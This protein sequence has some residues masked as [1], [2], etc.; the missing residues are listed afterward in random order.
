MIELYKKREFGELFSDTF[1]FIRQNGKHFFRNFLLINGA[2]IL[3]LMVLAYF[4][5]K[6]YSALITGATIPGYDTDTMVENYINNN[7][8]LVAVFGILFVLVACLVGFITYAYTPIY[9][10]LYSQSGNAGFGSKEIVKMLKDNAGK[11]IIFILACLLL[12]IP[13]FIGAGIVAFVMVIT[14]IGIFCLPLLLATI[15]LTY[16]N[17]LME[18]L[19]S[20]KGVFDCFEYGMKLTFKKFWICVGSVALFYFMIQIVQ[21]LATTIPYMA[22]IISVVTT[23][24]SG[25]SEES[26]ALMMTIMMVFYLFSFILGIIGNT[27]IQINQCVVYFSLKEETENINTTSVI[28]QIG[29]SGS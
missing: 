2:F 11:L 28:D 26:L 22:G 6:V 14:V 21:G 29:A 27:F 24:G 8:P 10:L 7:A 20:D 18:Y 17:A 4:F 3:V 25:N 23:T 9:L 12:S 1:A 15:T 13:V 19:G 16:N 5:I